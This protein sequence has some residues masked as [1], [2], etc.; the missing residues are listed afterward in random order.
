MNVLY[1]SDSNYAK[2]QAWRPFIKE[3][4]DLSLIITD[5]GVVCG[6]RKIQLKNISCWKFENSTEYPSRAIILVASELNA[7]RILHPLKQFN[8]E[9]QRLVIGEFLHRSAFDKEKLVEYELNKYN[10]SI[11]NKA[12]CRF[13]QFQSDRNALFE[14]GE[15]EYDK[16][17]SALNMMLAFKKD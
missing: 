10:T 1:K 12:S 15:C 7:F 13:E 8:E 16:I 2:S 11:A 14:N 6:E 9:N 5:E 3:S 17:T 4:K